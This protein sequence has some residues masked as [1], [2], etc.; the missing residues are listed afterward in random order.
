MIF[1]LR[2]IY[3]CR[4][5][6]PRLAPSSLFL[7]TT[8]HPRNYDHFDQLPSGRDKPARD[9]R[10]I[11]RPKANVEG[12]AKTTPRGQRKALFLV[13]TRGD[14]VESK[15]GRPASANKKREERKK[16]REVGNPEWSLLGSPHGAQ[17]HKGALKCCGCLVGPGNSGE[18]KKGGEKE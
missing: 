7:R 14:G 1:G 13:P 18:K 16:A 12:A 9:L 17:G 3:C 4:E 8:R 15:G 10:R 5:F 2:C 11:Q 6:K